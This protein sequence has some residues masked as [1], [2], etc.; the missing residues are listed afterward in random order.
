[1][2]QKTQHM[3]KVN[4]FATKTSIVATKVEKNYKTNVAT[5]KSMSRYNEE[6]NA[7]ISNAIMIKKW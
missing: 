2:S 3:V 1:M 7:K 5:Q 6:L 4:F